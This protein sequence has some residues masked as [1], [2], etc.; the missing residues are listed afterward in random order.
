MREDACGFLCSS[1]RKIHN[2]RDDVFVK[3]IF[4]VKKKNFLGEFSLL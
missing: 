4:G 3:Y 1:I 2:Q